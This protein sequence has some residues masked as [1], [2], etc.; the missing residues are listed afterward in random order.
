MSMVGRWVESGM[1]SGT[2]TT[3]WRLCEGQGAVL[4]GQ[5][6]G[7]GVSLCD[8]SS[9]QYNNYH[10][11][12]RGGG[13]VTRARAHPD[14]RGVIAV[15]NIDLHEVAPRAVERGA[16]A[17]RAVEVHGRRLRMRPP[18]RVSRGGTVRVACHTGRGTEAQAA[19]FTVAFIGRA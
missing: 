1:A 15:R 7:R 16:R 11:C 6:A 14:E 13:T 10:S 12:S 3:I 2:L 8:R 19:G 17:R 5:C 9:A 4:S 18:G